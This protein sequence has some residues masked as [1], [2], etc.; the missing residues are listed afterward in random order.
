MFSGVYRILLVTMNSKKFPAFG[1]QDYVIGAGFDLV[2]IAL[3][4]LPFIALL[5]LP[6]PE[7]LERF[8]F[9]I[10]LLLFSCG[11]FLVFVFNGWDVA[12]F[13]Y[14]AKRTSFDYFVYMLT[15]TETSSLAG[16]FIAEFWWLIG[17]FIVSLSISVFSDLPRCW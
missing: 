3:F 8:R 11:T 9:W 13:S 17:F 4:F 10:K 15:N 2:T 16:D 12:Y 1:F 14:T 7:R 5:F 6:L